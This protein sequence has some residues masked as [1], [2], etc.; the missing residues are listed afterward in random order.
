MIRRVTVRHFKRFENEVFDLA[1]SVVLAGPN[2]CGKSTLLQ[3]IC[4]WKFALDRW[5]EHA[6]ENR[7][8]LRTGAPVQ[9]S[10][11]LP[12]PLREMNLLW[13]RRLVTSEPSGEPRPIEILVEADGAGG[14]WVCGVEIHYTNTEMVYVRPSGA[15]DLDRDALTA[16]PPPPARDLEVT[17]LPALFGIARDEPRHERGMQDLLASSGR[18]GDILRNLLFEVSREENE[19]RRLT[20]RVRGLFG[21]E[22]HPPKFHPARPYLLCEYGEPGRGGE[23]LDLAGAGSGALQA[24]LLFAFLHARRGAVLLLDEPD[25]HQHVML[26]RQVYQ[27]VREVA[28]RRDGQVIAATHS[29]VVLNTTEPT[30]ILGFFGSGPRALATPQDRTRLVDALRELEVSD[31]LRARERGAILYV[32]DGSDE[33]IL[34]EWARI[35]EHPARKFFALPNIRRLRGRLPKQAR[36][37]FSLLWTEFPELPGLCLLDG[38]NRD[39]KDEGA[40]QAGFFVLQWRRYEIENY[41][42]HPDA[43]RRFVERTTGTSPDEIDAEFRRQLPDGT[44][45]FGDHPLLRRVKASED[46]LLPMLER[47]GRRTKKTDLYQ[48]AAVMKPEEIHPEVREKLDRIAEELLPKASG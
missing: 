40:D 38:N 8:D 18:P 6:A 21:I 12:V 31:L 36:R 27:G 41:L 46:I 10:E 2:N 3:A 7:N 42:L 1:E 44:D 35:L 34:R 9:R 11:F 30:E 45:F 20:E 28:S 16:F 26:Q 17:H 48:L 19:W 33:D 15:A 13:E 24:I 23:R 43:I 4:T 32:E 22:L 25:A 29:E 47:A 39:G 14:A 5:A 37:H